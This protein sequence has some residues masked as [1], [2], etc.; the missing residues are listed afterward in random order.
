LQ[1]RLKELKG[2]K[3][4]SE[5]ERLPFHPQATASIENFLNPNISSRTKITKAELIEHSKIMEMI[6]ASSSSSEWLEN[7]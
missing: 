1:S 7:D 6:Y 3:E 2:N 5:T 4:N